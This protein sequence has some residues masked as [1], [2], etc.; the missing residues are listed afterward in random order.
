MI[1]ELR[2]KVIELDREMEI[3]RGALVPALETYFE[4]GSW[5]GIEQFL[6]RM[7]E[8]KSELVLQ[9]RVALTTMRM[10]DSEFEEALLLMEQAFL[11]TR[12][13]LIIG[14]HRAELSASVKQP[15]GTVES[16][17]PC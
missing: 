17:E 14:T 2:E 8:N 3:L 10:R 11:K 4:H 5:T 15:T 12:N 9:L 7:R 6:I 1:P 13:N 16:G